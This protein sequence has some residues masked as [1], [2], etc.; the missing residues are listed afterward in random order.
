MKIC[1][2]ATLENIRKISEGQ[3]WVAFFAISS[4]SWNNI[5]KPSWKPPW[6]SAR[7]LI[8]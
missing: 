6:I 8:K 7:V 5:K 2:L 1:H 3:Q 4:S